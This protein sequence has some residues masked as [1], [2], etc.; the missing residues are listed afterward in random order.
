M[1]WVNN[2]A[3][4]GS[5]P[6]ST[7]SMPRNMVLE[8]QASVTLPPSTWTSRRRCPSMRVMG[9]SVILAT[10]ILLLCFRFAGIPTGRWRLR[11]AFWPA[12]LGAAGG[13]MLGDRLAVRPHRADH[14]VGGEHCGHAADH[15]EA[16]LVGRSLDAKARHIG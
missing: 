3:S 6:F 5:R 13:R 11:A 14:A 1:R 9:S 15:A 12:G 8:L 16:D 2:H 4:R 10:V 7:S